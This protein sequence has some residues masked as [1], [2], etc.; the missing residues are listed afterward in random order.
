MSVKIKGIRRYDVHEL[1]VHNLTVANDPSFFAEGVVV[2]NCRSVLSLGL[3]ADYET[4]EAQLR[5]VLDM[6]EDRFR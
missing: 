6:I 2:H 1:P 3:E 5:R 4:D